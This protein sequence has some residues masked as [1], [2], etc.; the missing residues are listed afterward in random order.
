MAEGPLSAVAVLH[1]LLSSAMRPRVAIAPVAS[2]TRVGFFLVAFWIDWAVAEEAPLTS[3]ATASGRAEQ[4][5][6]DGKGAVSSN[7]L[8]RREPHDAI[9]T[10]WAEEEVLASGRAEQAAGDGK[11]AVRSNGLMRREVQPHEA[12]P[13]SLAEEEVLEY[14]KKKAADDNR[15][16]RAGSSGRR[17]GRRRRRRRRKAKAATTT[18]TTS[19]TTTT[20]LRTT[21]TPKP[22][23]SQHKMCKANEECCGKL[24]CK[25][26]SSKWKC[27]PC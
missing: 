3:A 11:G 4:T 12:I 16:G 21:T 9:P 26:F 10:S 20:T 18:S 5:A 7:G 19:T 6:G 1:I 23:L 2:A 14:L 15:G 17:R 22:C 25:E 27:M 13:M 8:M 24:C